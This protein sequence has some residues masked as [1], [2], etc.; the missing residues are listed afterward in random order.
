MSKLCKYLSPLTTKISLTPISLPGILVNI[1]FKD[2]EYVISVKG[3]LI[4]VAQ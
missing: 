1:P 2:K 3:S 4:N